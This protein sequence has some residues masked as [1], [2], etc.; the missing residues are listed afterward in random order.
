[1]KRLS[2]T[3][4]ENFEMR[5]VA[6]IDE[7]AVVEKILRHLGLLGRRSPCG[8][9]W[10]EGGGRVR[11]GPCPP[12]ER[13]CEPVLDDPFPDYDTEPVLDYECA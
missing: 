12:V 7:G 4:P 5:I 10:Q 11:A 8:G 6:L 13:I 1:M 2:R 9:G 3:S